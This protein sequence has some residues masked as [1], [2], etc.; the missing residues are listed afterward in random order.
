MF[1]FVRLDGAILRHVKRDS[2]VIS[3]GGI[4]SCGISAVCAAWR[5]RQISSYEIP[6]YV[7]SLARAYTVVGISIYISCCFI[8][9]CM[10][11]YVISVCVSLWR[12]L[13]VWGLHTG[14]IKSM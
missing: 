2:Q 5:L 4:S 6:R 1:W 13:P 9:I 3:Y 10:D 14:K 7:I 11:I 12:V 8:Y